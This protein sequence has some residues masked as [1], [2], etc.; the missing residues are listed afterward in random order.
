MSASA[1]PQAAAA[2][3]E[4]ASL[5]G[6]E[7]LRGRLMQRA[8]K[9]LLDQVPGSRDVLPHLAALEAALGAQ[10]AVVIEQIA[11]AVAAKV[12]SQLRVLPIANDDPVMQDLL[13]RVHRVVRRNGAI[14]AH[15]LSPFDPEATVVITEASHTDFMNALGDSAPEHAA[16]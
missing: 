13:G 7:V 14:H 11:P 3:G 9:T 4:P 15:S 5:S 10:G 8:L 16:R 1:D 12:F 2:P 6:A